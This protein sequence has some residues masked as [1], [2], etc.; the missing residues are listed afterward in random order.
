MLHKGQF[1]EAAQAFQSNLKEG[2]A[3]HSV[4]ILLACSTETIQKAVGNVPGD[5]LFI[6]PIH[7]KGKDCYRLGWG[8]YDSEA[9]AG[10]GV[11]GVPEYFRQG[12]AKPKV[13]TV[14]EILR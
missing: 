4:Q 12:G 3:T 2:K 1:A 6:L 5:E 7:Y 10:A 8:L 9:K 14:A 13:V 11:H